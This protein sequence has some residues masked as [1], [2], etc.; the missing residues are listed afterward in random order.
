MRIYVFENIKMCRLE[1]SHVKFQ[2]FNCG[3]ETVVSVLFP[4]NT[5]DERTKNFLYCTRPL[6][7]RTIYKQFLIHLI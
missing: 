2:S 3:L 7:P 4:N 6:E 5:Q 1:L